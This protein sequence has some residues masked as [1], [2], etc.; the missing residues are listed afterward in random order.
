MSKLATTGI[1]GRE[2]PQTP[3]EDSWAVAA[4]GCEHDTF[5]AP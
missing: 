1:A 5:T 2:Q 3:P 4:D